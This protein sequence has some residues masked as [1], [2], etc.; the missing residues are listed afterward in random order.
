MTF[1]HLHHAALVHCQIC[2]T[3]SARTYIFF[4]NS[5][6]GAIYAPDPARDSP[7]FYFEQLACFPSYVDIFTL[8]SEET[9]KYINHK[10]NDINTPRGQKSYVANWEDATKEEMRAFIGLL[11]GMGVVKKGS[12][13]EYWTKSSVGLFDTPGYGRIMSRDRFM[14]IWS[15]L[16]CVDND[17]LPEYG[18][19]GYS[20]VQ[21]VQRLVDMV[22]HSFRNNINPRQHLSVDESIV[23]HKGTYHFNPV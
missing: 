2:R 16:H 21:K 15:N 12:I 3:I 6:Q 17:T 23:P 4:D 8:L 7:K 22:N 14:A 5:I 10:L 19:P 9:N 11:L 18:Q 1:F 20:P 13:K